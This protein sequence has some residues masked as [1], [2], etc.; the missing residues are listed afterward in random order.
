MKLSGLISLWQI[1]LL[2]KTPMAETIWNLAAMSLP[3]YH[4]ASLHKQ[5]IHSHME[6]EAYGPSISAPLDQTVKAQRH[7]FGSCAFLE[8]HSLLF[9]L[10]ILSVEFYT[11]TPELGS[12][13]RHVR[14]LVSKVATI[15]C[16]CHFNTGV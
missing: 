7:P 11:H 4:P 12:I 14:S 3:H 6:A 5:R 8:F 13:V 1:L 9:H 15:T 16:S 2:C 10:E